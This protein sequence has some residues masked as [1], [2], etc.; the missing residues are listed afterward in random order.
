MAI[1]QA[2]HKPLAMH[3]LPVTLQA[4]IVVTPYFAYLV[5]DL[6]CESAGGQQ[7]RILVN[8]PEV[9]DLLIDQLPHSVGGLALFQEACRISGI[10]K[11]TEL[12]T[13]PRQFY[14]V[15]ELVV[16]PHAAE[17]V[18]LNDMLTL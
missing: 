4:F 16:R 6:E 13:F 9:A 10:L 14:R 3:E 7:G 11:R 17:P 12:A 5:D 18:V 2:L 8:S 1:E 15:S